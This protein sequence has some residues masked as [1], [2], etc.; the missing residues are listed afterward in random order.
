M[1][2]VPL[3]PTTGRQYSLPPRAQFAPL[4]LSVVVAL[5]TMLGG[6]R[7][8]RAATAS[9]PANAPIIGVGTTVYID[10]SLSAGNGTEA[11]DIDINFNS[12]I[13]RVN[14]DAVVGPLGPG[15]QLTTNANNPGVVRLGLACV[16]AVSISSGVLLR[17][18]IQS[19]VPG[20]TGL[21][22]AR[23][24]LNEDAIPCTPVNGGLTVTVPTPTATVPPPTSTRTAAVP[25]TPV[26]AALA[27]QSSAPSS[28]VTGQQYLVSVTMRIRETRPGRPPRRTA[29]A[30]RTR[31]TISPGGMNRVLLGTADSI[32]PGQDKVFSWTV[33]APAT[34]GTYEFP[35]ALVR[36]GVTWFGD[37]TTN[38]AIAVS[39]PTPT[40]TATRTATPTQPDVGPDG[41]LSQRGG[42]L[43]TLGDSDGRRAAVQ[44]T[45]DDAQ[46]WRHDVDGGVQ[47]SAGRDQSL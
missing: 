4:V 47:L 27:M 5:L 10:L 24:S 18:P 7:A 28:M 14:G 13:V 9:L 46:Q 6:A 34:A 33:T 25:P 26:M 44:R 19:L 2:R 31:T 21:A 38:L 32:A 16:N 30:R 12:A 45:G 15:C 39:A 8:A 40:S 43:A 42:R 36:D 22:V 20:T 41:G 35:V 17:I 23:C 3:K 11:A 29:S 1:V 37:L